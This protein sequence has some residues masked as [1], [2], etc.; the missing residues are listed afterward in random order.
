MFAKE[1]QAKIASLLKETGAVT[2]AELME[3][4][5]VSIETVRRDLLVMDKSGALQ[6]VHGG[7][8]SAGGMMPFRDLQSRMQ[9]N[10]AQ[11]QEL[12]R[13]AAAFVEEGDT[14]AI[15]TGS[16]A[17]LLAEALKERL[18]RL[19]VVTYSLDVFQLLRGYKNF[20]IILCGG[21]YY[22]E[23][24]FLAGPLAVNMLSGIHVQKAFLF[25]TAVSL[26]AGIC[27][28]IPECYAMVQ[29]LRQSADQC[30]VLADSS[31]FERSDLLK[32]DDMLPG[33]IYIT[34]SDLPAGLKT[35]YME[36]QLTVITEV[37]K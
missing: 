24:N 32:Q 5:D 21:T 14:I 7:A 28:R 20:E 19:T 25:P 22:P 29:A 26:Q 16:T 10:V 11:K 35:M 36:N 17:V 2:T 4:F 1:R 30:Y 33:Y 37:E 23:E 13:T 18:T 8:V 12:C 6:R 9:D 34:D 31:K 3:R 15:D 27:N